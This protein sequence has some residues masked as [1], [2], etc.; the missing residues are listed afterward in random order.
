MYNE[1]KTREG[2]QKR[3][4]QKGDHIFEQKK[5][6]TGL[7]SFNMHLGNIKYVYFVNVN[8]NKLADTSL[9]CL[10]NN[11]YMLKLDCFFKQRLNQ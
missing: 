5:T 9:N 6:E 3:C 2:G 11:T 7:F 1:I 8:V 10:Q 4:V